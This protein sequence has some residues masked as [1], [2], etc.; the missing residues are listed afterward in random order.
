MIDAIY[1]NS[2]KSKSSLMPARERLPAC[3][4]ARVAL[5]SPIKRNRVE[6]LQEG[7]QL[8]VAIV[9]WRLVANLVIENIVLCKEKTHRKD[10]LKNLHSEKFGCNLRKCEL[11][12]AFDR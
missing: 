4:N 11:A 1:F 10:I 2:G 5:D 9:Y 3:Q 12:Y 7:D 6:N 8:M